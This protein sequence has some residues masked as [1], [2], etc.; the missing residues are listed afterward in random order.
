MLDRDTFSSCLLYESAP[1]LTNI[2]SNVPSLLRSS[3]TSSSS[4]CARTRR[5]SGPRDGLK[6]WRARSRIRRS[7]GRPSQSSNRGH[8]STS[9][10]PARHERLH[11]VPT[12]KTISGRFFEVSIVRQFILGDGED[13]DIW[14]LS[15]KFMYQPTGAR[16]ALSD[17][18]RWCHRLDEVD[19]MHADHCA[20]N[21]VSP[22]L[23]RSN[24]ESDRP[25]QVRLSR[26]APAP[27]H[28]KTGGR[29]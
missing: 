2:Y 13:D 24:H 27:G 7:S 20:E 19:A 6:P 29:G 12:S 26:C 11:R 8:R 18:N 17:G 5:T 1:F 28:R 15:L 3:G 9:E 16:T 14:Q 23:K 22:A 25:R 10:I 4:S 21:I